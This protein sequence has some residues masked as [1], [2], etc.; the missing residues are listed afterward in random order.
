MT[1]VFSEPESIQLSLPLNA[2]YVSAARL[3]ASSV[4]NRLGF[5]T[6][7]IEDIKAAVS[8]A[9]TF[10]IKKSPAPQGGNFQIQFCMDKDKISI[11]IETQG[12]LGGDPG[13]MSLVMIEALMDQF[14]LDV[15]TGGT[16]ISMVKS[17]KEELF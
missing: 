3:T 5:G 6:D 11:A 9:C 1:N 15:G 7:E 8:E 16:S 14:T 17:H 10:V 12:D 13:E 2:A 4:A